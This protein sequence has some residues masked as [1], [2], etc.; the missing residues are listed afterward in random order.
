MKSIWNQHVKKESMDD[1]I[2]SA[3]TAICTSVCIISILP[4]S[5]MYDIGYDIGTE[6]M[7]PVPVMQ[8]T[9]LRRSA[10]LAKKYAMKQLSQNSVDLKYPHQLMDETD[11]PYLLS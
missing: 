6:C 11:T 7:R 2:E 3:F 5:T 10:R 9:P 4:F 1:N 8:V